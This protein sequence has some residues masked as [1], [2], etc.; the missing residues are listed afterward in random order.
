MFNDT[1][2]AL[3]TY[4]IRNN[5]EV[6]DR[7]IDSFVDAEKNSLSPVRLANGNGMLL[8]LNFDEMINLA[9]QKF[10]VELES[11]ITNLVPLVMYFYFHSS[12]EL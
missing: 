8:G 6:I 9:N 7:A 3:I 1:S 4:Q 12:I 11:S 5:A 2:N 10:S